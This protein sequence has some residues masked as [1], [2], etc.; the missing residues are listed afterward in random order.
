MSLNIVWI[1]DEGEE[2]RFGKQTL[3]MKGHQV[4]VMETTHQFLEW[5]DAASTS[6]VDVFF[7][8]LMMK[9]DKIDMTRLTGQPE[10]DAAQ[11]IDTGIHLH[12]E[13]RKKFP[14]K[15]IV[16]LTIVR[17]IPDAMKDDQY[18][19]CVLKTSTIMPVLAVAMKLLGRE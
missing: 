10:A 18:L 17:R 1:D 14:K 15:P 16:V 7:L 13:I 12:R 4:L 19:E 5:L 8:D 2:L 9:I 6:A 3:Q 11:H